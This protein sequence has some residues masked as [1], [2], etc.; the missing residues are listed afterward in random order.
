[1]G[2]LFLA[3]YPG[4][5]AA[6]QAVADYHIGGF[7]LFG[8]DLAAKMP[9]QIRSELED[10]QQGADLPLLI[11]V[12]EEGGTVTRVSSYSQYRDTPFPSP[13]SLY[14][15][16]GLELV[17]ATEREK[18]N[19]LLSVGICVNLAPVCDVTTDPNAFMYDRSLGQSPEDTGKYVAAVVELMHS[20]G[21]GNVLKHFPGYGNNDDTHIGTAVDDRSLDQLETRDLVPFQAGIDSGCDAIM[22][23]HTTIACLDPQLPGSLSPAVIGYLRQN[24]GFDGVIMTDDLAME[25]ITDVYG[26]GESAVMAVLAGNDILCCSDYDVQYQAVLQAV[27]DGRISRER[28]YESVLR[29]LRWKQ[30]LGLIK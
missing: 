11:A 9:S 28:L 5:E 1:M 25:A 24:M 15:N 6:Q 21:V 14:D 20:Q 12:D 29:V 27:Q 3:R 10:L 2:Q 4:T 30:D 17:L 19:L 23:S 18:C 26:V 7:V 8:K 22:V 13:R 16:G